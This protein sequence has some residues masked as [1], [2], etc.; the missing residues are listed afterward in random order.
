M[1]IFPIQDLRALG[2]KLDGDER[3]FMAGPLGMS[4][5]AATFLDI[6]AVGLKL[7]GDER[8]LMAGL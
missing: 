7:D 3:S 1:I 6:R 5:I 8:S 2:L 4:L